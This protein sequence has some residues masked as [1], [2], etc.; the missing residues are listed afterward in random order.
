MSRTAFRAAA[1]VATLALLTLWAAVAAATA[2][3]HAIAVSTD[4]AYGATVE[5][6]PDH[7]AVTFDETVAAAESGV[8]VTDR[9]GRRVDAGG[10][11]TADGGHTVGV[12]LPADP[13]TGTYVF[14]WV[15]LSADG[16][17]VT[18]STVFGIGTP[19]DLLAAD[20][21]RD[22][23]AVAA[24]GAA[25]MLTATGYFGLA[26]AVGVPAVA[27]LVSRRNPRDPLVGQHTRTGTLALARDPLVGQLARAG[28]LTL[29]IASA[30]TVTL[31]PV[32]LA[33]AAGWT[34]AAV[35]TRSLLSP[36]SLAA[37]ART[38]T[39][40]L[41]AL[42][43]RAA[44]HAVSASTPASA[45]APAPTPAPAST[46]A[47]G[48]T[49]APTPAS[50]SARAPASTPAS[51]LAP[52]PAPA[53][54]PISASASASASGEG[55]ARRRVPL[56]PRVVAA[57]VLSV[58]LLVSTALGGHA[59]AGA[60]RWL[61]VATTTIHLA[62]M[63]VWLGGVTLAVLTLRRPGRL[64]F[65]ARYGRFALTAVAALIL[66]GT[67]QTWRATTPLAAL[68]TTGWGRLL[69]L[70]L[71]LVAAALVAAWLAREFVRHHATALRLEL[72]TQTAVLIVTAVLAGTTPARDAYNPR[73]SLTAEAGPLHATV[74]IDGTGVGPQEFT[75]RFTDSTGTPF[76][77]AE[78]TGRLT[79]A[80]GTIPI[81]VAFR[82]VEPVDL[83]PDHFVSQRVRVPA[84]GEWRL[85][86]T[87]RADR[88]TAYT[89]TVP[90][91]VW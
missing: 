73:A 16:H 1:T 46:S 36:P 50:A 80:D 78:V 59:V 54:A 53:P 4:P 64:E 90:Y 22:P 69:L 31:A 21:P 20:P 56:R 24:D 35:W 85:R 30:L 32:R 55:A 40:A 76:T 45:S 86:V 18:G 91:R 11:F 37:L 49:S 44:L 13:P 67:Y 28:A 26:L 42:T 14:T 39:A 52:T 70:E 82:R 57:A 47:S 7:V 3:A 51:A 6:A 74:D 38:I 19:P 10:L 81:D 61:A 41:L 48:P 5:R 29:A 62:A 15:V 77:P 25:R 72:A 23:L 33:G 79:K 68:W 43:F 27:R 60:D 12:R 71:A 17:T 63:A 83:G 65:A 34:D 88:T 84:P 66:T 75:L 58:V 8:H 89:V 2:G 9:D 87:I